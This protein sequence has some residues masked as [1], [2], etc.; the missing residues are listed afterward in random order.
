MRVIRGNKMGLFGLFSRKVRSAEQ[1]VAELNQLE[2]DEEEAE[3]EEKRDVASER[4]LLTQLSSIYA[5]KLTIVQAQDAYFKAAQSTINA[6]QNLSNSVGNFFRTLGMQPKKAAVGFTKTFLRIAGASPELV[7]GG[8]AEI[9]QMENGIAQINKALA[10]EQAQ[11]NPIFQNS[12]NKLSMIKEQREALNTYLAILTREKKDIEEESADA[13]DMVEDLKKELDDLKA[14]AQSY[15][16][17]IEAAKALW[18]K[19]A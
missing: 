15:K 8:E 2:K 10:I 18:K 4:Q 9:G 19:A 6:A 16:A 11:A 7:S 13:A 14:Q 17:K 12:I 5:R 1:Y 3:A